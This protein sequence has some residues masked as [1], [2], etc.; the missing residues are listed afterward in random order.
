MSAAPDSRP[1]GGVPRNGPQRGPVFL[2]RASYRQ[3]RLTD[4]ARLMPVLG[5]LLWAVPLLWT[6]GES[7]SSAALLYLFG[8]WIVLVVA[9]AL[10]SRGM[11]GVDLTGGG[12]DLTGGGDAD[13]SV[14]KDG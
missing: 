7:F 6:R 5:A 2:E 4:A 11:R 8:V 3:R 1:P 9:A 10:L 13:G 12:V 14:G